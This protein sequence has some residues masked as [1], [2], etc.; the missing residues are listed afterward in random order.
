MISIAQCLQS[1][2]SCAN[3]IESTNGSSIYGT[4]S[5]LVYNSTCNKGYN[6]YNKTLFGNVTALKGYVPLVLPGNGFLSIDTS[7]GSKYSDY[8]FI[9]Q[10]S[11]SSYK[12]FRR[13]DMRRN[14]RFY[15][16]LYYDYEIQPNRTVFT[17]LYSNKKSKTIS[18]TINLDYSLSRT[19]KT[20][21]FAES[22]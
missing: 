5:Y 13:I 16:R 10:Q 8:T 12:A 17:K 15:V 20:E 2:E 4:T 3:Y 9:Y 22:N 7:T 14:F 18:A 11:V 6:Y 21:V 19:V 1:Q